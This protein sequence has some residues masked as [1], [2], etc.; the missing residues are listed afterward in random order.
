MTERM[1]KETYVEAFEADYTGGEPN[2]TAVYLVERWGTGH[3][4]DDHLRRRVLTE[5]DKARPDT[6]GGYV[7]HT[8]GLITVDGYAWEVKELR[9]SQIADNYDDVDELADD[10][11]RWFLRSIPFADGH[12]GIDPKFDVGGGAE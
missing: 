12:D 11:T 2:P 6:N 9:R 1:R 10:E 5:D 8:R 4:P 7:V 3:H